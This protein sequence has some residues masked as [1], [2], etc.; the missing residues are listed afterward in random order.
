MDRDSTENRT[1]KKQNPNCDFFKKIQVQ[2]DRKQRNKTKETGQSQ[3]YLKF[4]QDEQS[5]ET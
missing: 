4:V 2:R 1:E 5:K 3:C